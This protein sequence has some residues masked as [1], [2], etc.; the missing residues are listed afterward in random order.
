M[1]YFNEINPLT[2]SQNPDV[3]A[4]LI[5]PYNQERTLYILIEGNYSI[6]ASTKKHTYPKTGKSEWLTHQIELPKSGISWTVNT[7]EKKFLKLSHEGGLPADVRHYEGIVD[8][9]ELGISRAMGLGTDDN[10]ESSYTI[11]THSRKSEWDTSK[12]MSFT[13]SFLFEHGFFDLL[14]DLAA[15]IEKGII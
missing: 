4:A 5:D 9:E 1:H 7:I 3:I 11:Y 2:I 6:I 15:K 14:K 8:G 13:D 10:R 12:K